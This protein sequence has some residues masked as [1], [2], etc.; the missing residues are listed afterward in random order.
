MGYVESNLLDNENIIYK[1]KIHDFYTFVMLMGIIFGLLLFIV[2]VFSKTP[3]WALGL[4]MIV[5]FL[6]KLF[7]FLTIEIAL[8]NKRILYKTGII[9][10]S[11]F[12]LQ[13]N[14]VESARLD[15]TI[16]ERIIGAGTLVIS[17]TGG[18]SK[19]IENLS[20]PLDIRTLIYQQIEA[21]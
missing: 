5:V 19:P 18:H 1:G 9:A 11:V 7:F 12:E 15:Q 3:I 10:R 16:F 2:G 4:S 17:G 6:Y 21:N 20:K 13:L 8:T 14:K